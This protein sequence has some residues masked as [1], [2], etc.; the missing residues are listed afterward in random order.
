MLI[1]TVFYSKGSMIM[2][3]ISCLSIVTLILY[4][5]CFS[6]SATPPY[7][8]DDKENAG[9]FLTPIRAVGPSKVFGS[10]AVPVD[11]PS[12]APVL[13]SIA[14]ARAFNILVTPSHRKADGQTLGDV[15]PEISPAPTKKK[16]QASKSDDLKIRKSARRREGRLRNV[17]KKRGTVLDEVMG[18]LSPGGRK[19]LMREK[20]ALTSIRKFVREHR[21]QRHVFDASVIP[22]HSKSV[23]LASYDIPVGADE[24]FERVVEFEGRQVLQSD[25]IFRLEDLDENRRANRWRMSEGKS[26][27]DRFR[28][29]KRVPLHHLAQRDQSGYAIAELSTQSHQGD[30]G[31]M[32]FRFGGKHKDRTAYTDEKAAEGLVVPI[33]RAEFGA[34][35]RRYW[36]ARLEDLEYRECRDAMLKPLPKLNFAST[37]SLFLRT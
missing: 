5:M 20:E 16:L 32:H 3:Y 28:G 24:H 11:T 12:P 36:I 17:E 30:F 14:S 19:A 1:N 33:D 29:F 25:S 18:T 13:Q 15:M 37:A 22:L 31:D 23:S 7:A 34:W 21:D 4:T 8:G 10:P 6:V 27:V 9:T 2:K 35:K 26:P